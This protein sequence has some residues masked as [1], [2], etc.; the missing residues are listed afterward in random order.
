MFP[1]A[2]EAEEQLGEEAA[3]IIGLQEEGQ[4]RSEQRRRA[5]GTE[6]YAEVREGWRMVGYVPSWCC[7]SGLWQRAEKNLGEPS[8]RRS[9]S[10]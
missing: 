4:R 7:R 6:N 8:R 9:S 1:A 2:E 10:S 5:R 3:A